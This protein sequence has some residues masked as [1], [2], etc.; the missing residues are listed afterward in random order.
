MVPF[1][2]CIAAG[3]HT[4]ISAH[5]RNLRETGCFV[6]E[7]QTTEGGTCAII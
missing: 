4:K 3:K 6:R 1:L 2:F 7:W 5:C